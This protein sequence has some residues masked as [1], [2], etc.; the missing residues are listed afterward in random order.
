[1]PMPELRDVVAAGAGIALRPWGFEVRDSVLSEKP[2]GFPGYLEAAR[3]L[4]VDVNDYEENH[5]GWYP[6][7]PLLEATTFPHLRDDCIVCEVGPGTGRFSRLIAP[8]IANGELHLVD[9]SPWMVRFLA[10]YF[11]HQPQVRVHL[12]DGRS[13]PLGRER[14]V[15]VVFVAGT[16]VALKLGTIRLYALEFARVL[17]SGGVVIFDYIDPTTPEGWAHL[18]TDGSRLADVYTYHAPQVIDRVFAEAGFEG[19]ERQQLGKS[20]YFSARRTS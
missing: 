1:M 20:T 8:R 2:E 6:A 12:G 17:K 11:Q 3:R 10:S 18:Q 19:F 14:W 13:L 15:D 16:V 9:H 7:Q 5:L 4:G